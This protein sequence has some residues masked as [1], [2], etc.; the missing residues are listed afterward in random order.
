MGEINGE[1]SQSL[2]HAKYGF[3]GIGVMGFPMAQQLRAKMP[4]QA[5]LIICEVVEAQVEKFLAETDPQGGIGVAASPREVAE[6]AASHST[7][8]LESNFD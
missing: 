4:P 5:K 3:I 6:E 7:D 8:I 2:R 1:P